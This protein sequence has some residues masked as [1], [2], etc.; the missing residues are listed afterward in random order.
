MRRRINNVAT[1]FTSYLSAN[2][3]FFRPVGNDQVKYS[4]DNGANWKTINFVDGMYS[5]DNLNDYIHESIEANSDKPG[6]NFSISLTFVLT[7][8][9]VVIEISNKFQ[10]D[11]MDTNF[12][13]LIGFEKRIVTQTENY[14]IKQTVLMS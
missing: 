3:R 9:R 5:Y 8:Y 1:R 7:S 12:R 11:L 10:L 6:E 13:D 2:Q 4:P 14:Q